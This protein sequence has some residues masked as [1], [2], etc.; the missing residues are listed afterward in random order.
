MVYTGA[1]NISSAQKKLVTRNKT[2]D[3]AR[4]QFRPS[5]E[6]W[7]VGDGVKLSTEALLSKDVPDGTPAVYSFKHKRTTMTD[8][9]SLTVWPLAGAIVGTLAV[10]FTAYMFAAGAPADSI[11]PILGVVGPPVLGAVLGLAASLQ[12]NFSPR[13]GGRIEGQLL[14]G[15]NGLEFQP[16]EPVGIDRNGDPKPEKK[17]TK[18]SHRVP[19]TDFAQK[20]V[21]NKDF[22]EIRQWWSEYDR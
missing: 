22:Q 2:V 1:M 13:Q 4:S 12:E 18:A 21:S 5:Q 11:A 20:P 10:P 9:E 7:K 16:E 6:A 19:L 8:P 3:P 15:K 17:P 14:K